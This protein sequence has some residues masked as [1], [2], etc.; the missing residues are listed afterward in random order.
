MNVIVPLAGK[1]PIFAN[2]FKAFADVGDKPL[3]KKIFEGLFLTPEDKLIFIILEE[4]EKRFRA[5]EKLK[6]V[7]GNS[8]A[9]RRIKR[10]TRGAPESIL[11][12]ARDLIDNDIDVLIDLGDVLCD[13]SN[14]YKDMKNRSKNISGIIPVERRAIRGKLW[15]YVAA[16]GVIARELREKE[17]I[18]SAPWATMGL[19]YFSRGRDFVWAAE[20]MIRER[21]F[22]YKNTFFVGPAYNELI[23]RGDKI[24]IS[25]NKIIAVLGNPEEIEQFQKTR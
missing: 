17:E 16:E 25:E 10:L 3:I 14:L 18:P 1:D 6:E 12:G 20:K 7:F 9:V 11:L 13:T 23:K 19:Y 22:T 2:S 21:S 5:T 24:L 8:I 15:G 4:D